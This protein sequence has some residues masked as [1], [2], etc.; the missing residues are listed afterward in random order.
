MSQPLKIV[1]MGTADLAAASLRAL[2]AEKSFQILAAVSQPDKPRGRE[3]KLHPT[4]V[5]VAALE[6]GLLVLQPARA[7]H[8]DFLAQLASLKPDLVAVAAY[9]QILPPALLEIPPHGCLNVHTSLLPKYRGA[10]PIQWAL[11]N[12]DAQTG[13]TIMRMDAGLDTGAIL[14][15][16]VTPIR[17]EED[18]QRLHD[19]LAQLGGELLVKTIPEYVAGRIT[20]VPQPAEGSTYARKLNKEDGRVDWTAPAQVVWNRLR[21]FTPWPGGFTTIPDAG[22]TP[23]LLK[24]GLARLETGRSGKPGTVLEAT[25]AG[26]V[27]ACGTDALRLLEVQREGGRRMAAADFL[28]G[29]PLPNGTQLGG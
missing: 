29:H 12:G 22:G 17:D 11:F 10:A 21:A 16:V 24:I 5:K 8:S 2:R 1:F 27:V 28:A 13:V 14:S 25:R 23:R 19:R 6:A 18:A 3:L 26:M 4:P 7:R 20:P 9:G 15:Q